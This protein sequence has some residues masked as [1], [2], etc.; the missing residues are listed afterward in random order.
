MRLLSCR[1]THLRAPGGRRSPLLAAL[2]GLALVVGACG[3]DSDEADTTDTT[4]SAAPTDADTA[5]DGVDPTE[6]ETSEP[7]TTEA[8]PESTEDAGSA[9]DGAFP[10]TVEHIFGETTIEDEPETIVA[11]SGSIPIDWLL[12]LG[13]ED[14]VIVGDRWGAEGEYQ[15]PLPDEV[16]VLARPE[17]R[18]LVNLEELAA[19][20]PDLIIGAGAQGAEPDPLYEL[21]EQIAPVVYFDAQG[22]TLDFVGRPIAEATGRRTEYDRI[23]A[24]YEAR[25]ADFADGVGT[26][27]DGRSV[28]IVARFEGRGDLLVTEFFAGTGLLYGVLG[29]DAPA[30]LAELEYEAGLPF[31]PISTEQLE[32]ADADVIVCLLAVGS[33]CD[34]ILGDPII[35]GL[36]AISGGRTATID[37]GPLAY[38]NA[39]LAFDAVMDAIEELVVPLAAATDE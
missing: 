33:L 5:E 11:L 12:S 23:V 21:I 7:D 1:T 27:V 13:V 29:F 2:V 38:A 37:F 24:D 22:T 16:V 15:A 34:E 4:E 28:S 20:D 3:S 19:I 8:V 30:G 9:G 39:P 18:S 14:F 17:D 25:L 31:A 6:P 32:L 26:T 10:V 36:D 35:Q